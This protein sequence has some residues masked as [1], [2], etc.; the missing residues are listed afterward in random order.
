MMEKILSATCIENDTAE[1][2]RLYL[3]FEKIEDGWIPPPNPEIY[4]ISEVS[5][6]RE[7]LRGCLVSSPLNPGNPHRSL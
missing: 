4:R 6:P 5:P 1:Q 7:H 2:R 3:P